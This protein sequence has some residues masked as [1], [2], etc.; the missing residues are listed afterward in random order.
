MDE[1][2]ARLVRTLQDAAGPPAPEQLSDLSDLDAARL[3]EFEAAWPQVPTERRLLILQA[4]RRLADEHIELT[5]EAINRLSLGDTD[6]RVRQ[7]AVD[8]LWECEDS[9]L[10]RP[11][12]GLLAEDSSEQV[13]RAAAEALGQFVYLGELEKLDAK[14]LRDLEEGLLR[15]ASRDGSEA[16][17]LAA[18]ASLGYSS[19]VEVQQ[20]IQQVYD[21]HQEGQLLAALRAM[22]RSANAAWAPLVVTELSH[23]GPRV[24]QEAARAAGELELRQA[25]Q[26]LIYLLEDVDPQ[27]RGE[28]IWSLGQVGGRLALEALEALSEASENPDEAQLIEDALD[29][30]AFLEGT[31]D[32]LLFDYDNPEGTP[33]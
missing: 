2:F 12:L 24:R 3:R 23:A 20:L 19:R 32:L 7:A 31:P 14:L 8:N 22:G 21:T 10:V 1:D 13:R 26:E 30:L 25:A 29:N 9:G 16:V 6:A 18:L 11:L 17:R 4:L 15:S 28:A 5:F 27:V 33:D